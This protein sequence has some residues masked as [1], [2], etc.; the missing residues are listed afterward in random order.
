MKETATNLLK[1]SLAM[2]RRDAILKA[3]GRYAE[4]RASTPQM[5]KRIIAGQ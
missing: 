5:L 3:A 1:D 4:V 2:H